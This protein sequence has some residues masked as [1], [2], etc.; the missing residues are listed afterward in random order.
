MLNSTVSNMM[1]AL[2]YALQVSPNIFGQ[3]KFVEC[4]RAEKEACIVPQRIL[5]NGDRTIVFWSDGDK[6]IVKC[7][8]GQEFDE[9]NGFVAALAK[10]LYGSTSKVKRIISKA[11]D[12]IKKKSIEKEK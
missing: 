7:A 9:Y 10:K 11:K 8:E 12:N 2:S 4:V 3:P 5:Y 6:T 1:D